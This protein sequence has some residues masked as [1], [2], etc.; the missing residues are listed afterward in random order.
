MKCSM[1]S[2]FDVIMKWLW[3]N[4]YRYSLLGDEHPFTSYFDVHQGD[5]VLTHPQMGWINVSRA[6]DPRIS[7]SSIEVYNCEAQRK[8][9]T[10]SCCG[11]RW[12]RSWCI[13]SW[14][15]WCN[16]ETSDLPRGFH[17]VSPLKRDLPG[18]PASWTLGC[19]N[20]AHEEWTNWGIHQQSWG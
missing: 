2:L 17:M 13:C 15:G 7:S 5:R 20:V 8:P 3:I 19:S 6:S 4:T 12:Q 11:G 16:H 9:L 1:T 14:D 18:V 10:S